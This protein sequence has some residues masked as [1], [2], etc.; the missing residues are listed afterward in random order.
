M[1]VGPK[2]VLQTRSVKQTGHVDLSRCHPMAT[3]HYHC[4]GREGR[5]DPHPLACRRRQRRAQRGRRG[6]RTVVGRRRR[7]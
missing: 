6:R 7:H 3:T 2:I 4:H 1:T 5:D